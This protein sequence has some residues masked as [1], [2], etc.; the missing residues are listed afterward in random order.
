MTDAYDLEA[1]KAELLVM[2]EEEM[3]V[4]EIFDELRFEINRAD[5]VVTIN[6]ERQYEACPLTFGMMTACAKALKTHSISESRYNIDGCDTCDYG[7]VYSWTLVCTDL[8][9]KP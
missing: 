6:A 2:I 8:G 1:L 4:V 9:S 3:G 5:D 7:S